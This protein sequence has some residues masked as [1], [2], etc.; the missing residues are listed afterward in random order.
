MIYREL[1]AKIAQFAINRF[2]GGDSLTS[3]VLATVEE[4]TPD[5]PTGDEIEAEID[6]INMEYLAQSARQAVVHWM[7]ESW[8]KEREASSR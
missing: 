1:V 6:R 3:A 8:A 7:R 2:R 4:F 5:E